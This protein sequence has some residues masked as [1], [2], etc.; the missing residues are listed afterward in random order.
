MGTGAKLAPP[1]A[2]LGMGKFEEEKNAFNSNFDLL[3]R[4]VLWKRFIGDVLM[5]FRG[6][7]QECQELVNWLNS[8]YPGVI[9]FKHE[10]STEKVEFWT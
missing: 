1:Y 3:D 5:L 9:K 2:C 6:S 8:P 4:I 10:Y 7:E